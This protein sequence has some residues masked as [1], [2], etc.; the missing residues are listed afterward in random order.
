M[1]QILTRGVDALYQMLEELMD[2]GRLEAGKEIR[3]IAPFD[4]GQVL[5]ELCMTS[6]VLAAARGLFLNVEGPSQISVDGDIVKVRRIAQ[7]LLL[8]AIKYT[9]EGGIS[10]AW[11]TED[12]Q[13][14]FSVQDTGPG[15]QQGASVPPSQIHGEGIGLSIVQRLCELLEAKLEVESKMGI[16]TNFR[17]FFPLHYTE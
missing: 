4:V 10:V 5:S 1:R 9:D 2:M 17:V 14:L 16:G 8:N 7:N 6:Q 15:L 12:E 11:K 13:L 3:R